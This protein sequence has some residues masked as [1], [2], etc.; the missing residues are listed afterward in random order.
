MRGFYPPPS[1]TAVDMSLWFDRQL[2]RNL[3]LVTKTPA[4]DLSYDLRYDAVDERV[5]SPSL[6]AGRV[7]SLPTPDGSA[8]DL[9]Y[10]PKYEAVERRAAGGKIF[11]NSPKRSTNRPSTSKV[12]TYEPKYSSVER[13]TVYA[14]D[15][16]TSLGREEHKIPTPKPSFLD[17]YY[18]PNMKLVTPESI[19]PGFEKMKGR[20]LRYMKAPEPEFSDKMYDFNLDV[21]DISKKTPKFSKT[22]RK[23]LELQL[24]ACIPE[25]IYTPSY[26][27][28]EKRVTSP[29]MKRMVGRDANPLFPVK[30]KQPTSN[31]RIKHDLVEKRVAGRSIRGYTGRETDPCWE[32]KSENY[33][34][35]YGGVTAAFDSTKLR[36]TSPPKFGK[37]VGREA[38]I[39]HQTHP[40]SEKSEPGNAPELEGVV[41]RRPT[42]RFTSAPAR[43]P[44][45]VTVAEVADDA[46]S[47]VLEARALNSKLKKVLGS[48]ISLD[49]DDVYQD[50]IR[51]YE[52]ERERKQKAKIKRNA[53]R[54]GRDNQHRNSIS[55]AASRNGN[56]K[57]KGKGK[58]AESG[59][60]EEN[61]AE[62]LGIPVQVIT[63][64]EEKKKNSYGS[65]QED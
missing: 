41:P 23:T 45:T 57:G 22:A 48:K 33:D 61:L 35:V 13:K 32:R 64:F 62:F 65:N 56:G 10:Y 44:A 25:S 17:K 30:S 16:R 27:A 3:N 53:D 26:D 58:D 36:F 42:T 59:E 9:V 19:T 63:D 39:M 11:P 47:C 8:G 12:P 1:R 14:R 54:G 52:Q 28:A 20:E 15:M 49:L 46:N 34:K 6:K 7:E 4:F 38:P 29:D 37:Q 2:K 43:A 18:S 50:M 55:R 51:E 31:L 21:I 60:V 5:A 40:M 24:D